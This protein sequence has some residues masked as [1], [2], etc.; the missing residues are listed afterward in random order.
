MAESSEYQQSEFRQSE[1]P[2]ENQADVLAS[3][4][5]FLP[6]SVTPASQVFDPGD[7]VIEITP[8]RERGAYVTGLLL[9]LFVLVLGTAAGYFGRGFFALSSDSAPGLRILG[10]QP[11]P[12][13]E[14]LSTETNSD[15]VFLG[16]SAADQ[17]LTVEPLKNGDAFMLVKIHMG[18]DGDNNASRLIRFK[19]SRS[20]E[21]GHT[22]TELANIPGDGLHLVRLNGGTLIALSTQDGD[23]VV[24]GLSENGRTIWAQSFESTVIDRTEVAFAKT[25]D[26]LVIM[27]PSRDRSLSRLVSIETTGQIAWET[28]FDRPQTLQKPLIGI[29]SL[30]QTYAVLGPSMNSIGSNDQNIVMVDKDGHV[31]RQRLL[32]LASDDVLINIT[33]RADGGVSFL[34]AGQ[35]PRMV[36]MDSTGQSYT[37]FE[38]AGANNMIDSRLVPTERGEIL[39]ANTYDILGGSVSLTLEVRSADGFLLDRQSLQLP[40]GARLDSIAQVEDK[41]LLI[42]GSVRRERYSIDRYMPTD[43]F[44][45]KIALSEYASEYTVTSNLPETTDA[46]GEQATPTSFVPSRQSD[47][48]ESD[49]VDTIVAASDASPAIAAIQVETI[50]E[51]VKK[52]DSNDQMELLSSDVS[53]DPRQVEANET[54]QNRSTESLQADI[55]IQELR[56]DYTCTDETNSVVFPMTGYVLPDVMENAAAT[57]KAHTDVCSA[58]NLIPAPNSTPDC[59]LN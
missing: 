51:T 38:L 1:E 27:A 44:V 11:A 43:L 9:I 34:V 22:L 47:E 33:D 5:D 46:L 52:T 45:Q 35:N 42:A 18:S 19:A 48:I 25:E 15:L 32:S 56:C 54:P 57:A 16:S 50:S 31:L 49:K 28:A 39:I 41:E 59:S 10:M 21:N 2:S 7:G 55:V 8:E 24:S 13:F 29:D 40:A 26:G 30:G 14:A 12:A 53:A 36:E 17:L 37:S 6:Q 4:A 3:E 58:A 20:V 23:L